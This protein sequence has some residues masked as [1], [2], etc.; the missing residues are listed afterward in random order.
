MPLIDSPRKLACAECRLGLA[1]GDRT[2]PFR[3][4]RRTR[5]SVLHQQGEVVP[6]IGYLRSGLVLL[7][8]VAQSG[9]E[10]WC[11]I[12]GREYVIGFESALGQPAQS[13]AFA[14]SNLLICTLDGAEF[15]SWL[16]SLTTPLGAMLS[17][18]L[19]ELSRSGLDLKHFSGTASQRLGRFLQERIDAGAGPEPLDV[20]RVVLARMLGMRPETLSRAIGDLARGGVLAKGY[21]LRVADPLLLGR[22]LEQ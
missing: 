2:C 17:L 7:S 6:T 13:S 1:S 10:L 12:R 11:K 9:E 8:S 16:G 4:T 20:P 14:L 21:K 19:V 22:L 3:E 15:R 18:A 5:G